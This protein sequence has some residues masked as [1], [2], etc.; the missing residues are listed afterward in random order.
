ME[1]DGNSEKILSSWRRSCLNAG[2]NMYLIAADGVLMLHAAVAG[3]VVSGL[4]LIWLGEWRRWAWIHHPLFFWSHVLSIAVIVG[5]SWF[6][7][8][9]PLT[10]WEMALREK[11]GGET[12]S[13]SFIS[14]WLGK[15]LYV[16]APAWVFTWVYTAFGLL[17]V[18]SWG[19]VQ[20]RRRRCGVGSNGDT[21]CRPGKASDRVS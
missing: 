11:G 21:T 4:V 18:V 2:M 6:G 12:Y 14:H 15:L 10:E 9:C 3:F 17:V 16:E 7:R 8:L 13:G 19:W 20:F 5:Q 1:K